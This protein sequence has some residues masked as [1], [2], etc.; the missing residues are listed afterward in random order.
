MRCLR[1]GMGMCVSRGGR[2]LDGSVHFRCCER[3][4]L[5]DWPGT[6]IMDLG[7]GRNTFICRILRVNLLG[8]FSFLFLEMDKTPVAMLGSRSCNL[9]FV[10]TEGVIE[11]WFV[12]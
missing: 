12:G 5:V 7:I 2:G 10:E 8:I 9:D 3:E 6:S 1:G 4:R 11:T